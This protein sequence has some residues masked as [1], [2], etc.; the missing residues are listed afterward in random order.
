MALEE[1]ITASF[2]RL[3]ETNLKSDKSKRAYRDDWSRYRAWLKA[4]GLNVTEVKPRHI[5]DHLIW[6]RTTK[7]C[8]ASTCGRAL[9]V[10]RA[11]YKVL[12]RDEIM[13]SNPA[14]EV[15]NIESDTEPKTPYFTEEQVKALLDLPAESWVE[16]RDKLCLEVMLGIGWRR[17]EIARLAVEDFQGDTARGERKGGKQRAMGM[18]PFIRRKIDK[19]C[20]Y[21]EIE[22]GPIFVRSIENRAAIS[23]DIVYQIVKKQL[24]RVGILK[25]SPHAL[26][27]T[28]ATILYDRGVPLREIQ[29]A[30]SHA[31]IT[32]TERY[33]KVVDALK[34]APGKG[35]A[36]LFG[37][38]SEEKND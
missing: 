2:A 27:R 37:E 34:I 36:D 6:L 26:R 20:R 22:S 38:E 19:W 21:A 24:A 25:G 15:E 3:S 28:F 30:L 11:V 32:T 35:M 17:S 23:G 1:K 18:P 29:I 9:S 4:E 5:E 13:D 10:I 31:S 16:K 8:E 33:A 12:V 14:R 7:K